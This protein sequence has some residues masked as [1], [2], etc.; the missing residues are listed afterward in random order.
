M[1]NAPEIMIVT[2]KD[3]LK[4]KPFAP[5][6]S[7]NKDRNLSTMKTLK[8]LRLLCSPAMLIQGKNR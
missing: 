1:D 4:S 8:D 7:P 2:D 6:V 3:G 5:T